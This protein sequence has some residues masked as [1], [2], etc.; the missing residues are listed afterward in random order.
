VGG[1]AVGGC[2]L[3]T[4]C[5]R[6]P[7]AASRPPP[8]KPRL[9]RKKGSGWELGTGCRPVDEG[10]APARPWCP[11][12]NTALRSCC[13]CPLWKSGQ[14]AGRQPAWVPRKGCPQA[15][16]AATAA[17]R[18]RLLGQ[19]GCHRLCAPGI[20]HFHPVHAQVLGKRSEAG[21]ASG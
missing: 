8:R 6:C 5:V 12:P 18:T 14:V 3:L 9:H 11:L 7:S 2:L 16:L 1:A 17:A 20:L 13:A 19:G 15:P 10:A 21:C 4:G